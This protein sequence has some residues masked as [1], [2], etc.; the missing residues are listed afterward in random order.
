MAKKK[1]IDKKDVINARGG[2]SERDTCGRL[3]Q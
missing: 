2:I 1:T 3:W